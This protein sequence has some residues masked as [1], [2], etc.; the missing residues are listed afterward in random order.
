[1]IHSRQKKKLKRGLDYSE[2]TD[3]M[4]R[5]GRLILLLLVLSCSRE[6]REIRIALRMAGNNRPELEAVL[7]H[8]AVSGDS[9]KEQAARYLIRNMPR[10]MSYQGD[11]ETYYSMMDSLLPLMSSAEKY[12]HYMSVIA[13]SLRGGFKLRSDAR[14]ITAEFLIKSIEEA[15]Q[16]WKNGRWT[17]HLSFDEFCEYVLPYKIEEHQPLKEW[18]SIYSGMYCGKETLIND[19]IDEFRGEPEIAYRNVRWRAMEGMRIAYSDSIG[20]T[21]LYDLAMLKDVPYGD[22]VSFCD[23]GLLLYR[24]K[25]MPVAMD[26]VPGW[27]DRPGSHAWLSI[28]TRRGVP[29]SVNAFSTGDPVGEVQCRR[30]AK[31]HRRT[32]RPNE[33]ML[34]RLRQGYPIPTQ[35]S[36]IFFKDVTDEYVRC[37]DVTVK[38]KIKAGRNVYA[39]VFDNQKWI[40]VA[41]GKRKGLGKVFFEKLARN[42]LYMPVVLRRTGEQIPLGNPFFIHSDGR[43]ERVAKDTRTDKT[44]SI[45]MRRKYPAYWSLETVYDRT[46]GGMLQGS[47]HPDFRDAETI[48]SVFS[49]MDWSGYIQVSDASSYQYYRFC[50]PK[51]GAF[52]IG[53]IKLYNGQ[54]ELAAVSAFYPMGRSDAGINKDPSLAID[55]DALTWVTADDN[56]ELWIGLDY[57]KPKTVTGLYY[58]VRSDGNDFY[59]GYEYVLRQWNGKIW[60]KVETFVATKEVK[61]Q[62]K[63][64]FEG[65]LYLVTCNTTGTQSRP[66]VVKDGQPFWM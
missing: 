35:L 49:V 8:Y 12:N 28:L 66:F 15:F 43:I 40:P 53:E 37:E 30:F 11:F 22:C 38:V 18:R 2:Y 63:E 23:L 57:G 39:A 31:V 4:K 45:T 1:M 21:D 10:H 59:P 48:S 44:T 56:Q 62:F 61:H 26:Y 14:I 58:S 9:E 46:R 54:E 20:N 5:I 34:R 6:Q 50:A 7:K 16:L 27:A 64:L 47:N 33:E 24:S 60:E 51:G 55:N 3:D 25:G 13:D 52:D 36:D 29:L 19:A 41:Y 42:A 65:T 32:F 17:A